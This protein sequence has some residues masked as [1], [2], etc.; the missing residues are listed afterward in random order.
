VH[1]SAYLED[2]FLLAAYA[3]AHL[4]HQIR[5]ALNFLSSRFFFASSFCSSDQCRASCRGILLAVSK[6]PMIT[7][8]FTVR[9]SLPAKGRDLS[10]MHHKVQRPSCGHPFDVCVL[11]SG[12]PA[13]DNC[14]STAETT[15]HKDGAGKKCRRIKNCGTNAGVQAAYNGWL[16]M[17]WRDKSWNDEGAL[18]IIPEPGQT[19]RHS[20]P[21]PTA[22]PWSVHPDLCFLCGSIEHIM[23]LRLLILL[24]RM[25]W[26]PVTSPLL[27]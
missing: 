7:D 25:R 5:P 8:R 3:Q 2:L 21:F 14:Y 6:T 19:P 18:P 23:Q 20:F 12:V 1:R 22:Q 17:L 24:S 11:P 9:P 13:D 27:R 26:I 15:V 16:H 10:S 4:P